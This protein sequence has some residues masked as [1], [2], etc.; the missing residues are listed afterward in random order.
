MKTSITLDPWEAAQLQSLRQPPAPKQRQKHPKPWNKGLHYKA[1]PHFHTEK[2]DG[3]HA[4]KLGVKFDIT[5]KKG[6]VL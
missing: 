4:P 5:R 1:G 2:A 3:I 6:A